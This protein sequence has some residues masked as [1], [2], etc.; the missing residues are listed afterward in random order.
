MLGKNLVSSVLTQVPL[1]VLGI[2][3]GIFSTRIL[4]E[5]LK[6][7]FSLF[8][9]NT[10]LFVL[11]LSL[12]IQTGI[13]YFISSKKIS[14]NIVLGITITIFI[15][16]SILMMLFL[17]FAKSTDFIDVI[18]SENY[19]SPIYLLAFF[20]LFAITFA[21]S[22]LSGFFQSESKFILLNWIS[23]GNSFLN[24]VI[25]SFL[26]YYF[27]NHQL[28]TDFRF[29]IVL[30]ASISSLLLNFT[31]LMF[32]FV[33]R[34]YVKPSFNIKK[35]YKPFI[36]YNL[37][38][39]FGMFINFFNYRLDLWMINYYLKDQDL[40][41]YSLAANIVQIILF[42]STSIAVVMLPNLAGKDEID[43]NRTF[44]IISRIS[45]S[46]FVFITITAF[47]LS[48]FIIPLMYG[49][50][51][52][53]AVIPFQL[54]LPGILLSCVTQLFSSLLVSIRKNIFNII[55]CSLGLLV[56]TIGGFILIPIYGIVGASLVTTLSYFV[57][58]LFSY[59]FVLKQMNGFSLNLF[60]PSKLDFKMIQSI[61]KKK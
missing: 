53:G 13:V 11:V 61:I 22:I 4:G 41:Y 27:S 55:A 26:F 39:Y 7:V 58:F 15:A 9:A 50:E 60:I 56:T 20:L 14:K 5:D 36:L 31:I 40:S 54:L 33:K 25:F 47:L 59:I 51:F 57:I 23:I 49:V 42:V 34:I 32:F 35:Y 24:L 43:R 29:N 21:N 18:L 48:S 37:S 17:L 12:G 45:F 8:Q 1:F 52:S 6:G 44:A 2:L 16:S 30:L 38:I 10:Q 46:L 28:L 3:T 19:S